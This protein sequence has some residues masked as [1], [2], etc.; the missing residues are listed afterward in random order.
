M[1]KVVSVAFSVLINAQ[2][3]VCPREEEPPL[4][5]QEF[6]RHDARQPLSNDNAKARKESC[7]LRAQGEV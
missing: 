2:D 4:A 1:N 3:K 5:S 6:S 7:I